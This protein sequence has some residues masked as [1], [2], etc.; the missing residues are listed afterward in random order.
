MQEPPVLSYIRELTSSYIRLTGS[1]RHLF[2]EFYYALCNE[3]QILAMKLKVT[4]H[5]ILLI[6]G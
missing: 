3:K 5:K 4:T 2:L 1:R 6:L